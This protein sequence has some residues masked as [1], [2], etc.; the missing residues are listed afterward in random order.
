MAMPSELE[1]SDAD[2]L[3]AGQ[4]VLI[5]MCVAT[6]HLRGRVGEVCKLSKRGEFYI[7]SV[8]G[9]KLKSPRRYLDPV[10]C[11][12]ELRQLASDVLYDW[13][14]ATGGWVPHEE[15]KESLL[16]DFIDAVRAVQ[17]GEEPLP[18]D[19]VLGPNFA[20]AAQ[21]EKNPGTFMAG[22]AA[23]AYLDLPNPL[24]NPWQ[25][26]LLWPYACPI[27]KNKY[28]TVFQKLG[29]T[30]AAAQH[31]ADN[32]PSCEPLRVQP[33]GAKVPTT[34]KVAIPE[35]PETHCVVCLAESSERKIDWIFKECGHCCLCKPCVRK[36]HDAASSDL[37]ECPLC[38]TAST[39]VPSRVYKGKV[40]YA[41]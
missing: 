28:R 8:A 24:C 31:S 20:A 18:L 22:I 15:C 27:A 17:V 23:G 39:I 30:F 9:Q 34:A 11:G 38:R 6:E 32:D 1:Q 3:L 21:V 13:L 25:R 29:D 12:E 10:P 2:Q 33:I 19:L 5:S 14:P 36:L 4:R 40:F 41:N 35:T 16:I 7:V 26:N 37:V